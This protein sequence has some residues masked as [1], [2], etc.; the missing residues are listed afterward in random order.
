MLLNTT[1]S[2]AIE[3]SD[4]VGGAGVAKGGVAAVLISSIV[5]ETPLGLPVIITDAI[6][7]VEL[8]CRSSFGLLPEMPE[9][10]S[11]LENFDEALATGLPDL[12]KAFTV[13]GTL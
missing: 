8:T 4:K 3:T 2:N 7:S 12:S 13:T 1:N 6:P 9:R 10:A 11:L 5:N